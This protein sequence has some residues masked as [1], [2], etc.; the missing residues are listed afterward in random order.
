MNAEPLPTLDVSLLAGFRYAC[1]PE[2]GLCCFAEPRVSPTE[3][4]PLLSIAPG[5]RF[6][7]RGREECIASRSEGG[8]CALLGGLRCQGHA[9]RPAPCREFPVSVHLGERLQATVVLS[10]PG[11]DLHGLVR[12]PT[13]DPPP[14][15][16]GFDAELAQVRSRVRPDVAARLKASAARRR[17]IARFLAADDRWESEPEV[18]AR[19]TDRP[20][21]V[22]E[23][24]F[25][26]EPPPVAGDGLDLL[27]LTFAGAAGPWAIAAALGGWEVLELR[28][29]GGVARS[30][31]IV[32]PPER[33][34]PVA[35]DAARLLDRYLRYWLARDALFGVVHLSMLDDPRG[36]VSE[37]VAA[38]L[39]RIGAT[40]LARAD[41]LAAVRGGRPE[42][43]SADDVAL[44]IRATD[45][46]LLDRPTW[47]ARL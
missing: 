33:P 37:W 31:G 45:Q 17:R 25:P 34:P 42:R 8:A 19:W 47:G 22:P 39:A 10:C 24:A 18:R 32:P 9:A 28:E 15:P 4:A 7:T 13:A 14:A 27:P 26:V 44:G 43:L 6:V 40:V 29:T 5:L 16:I 11:V 21:E 46:D 38:E 12:D 35:P 1:R 3:R 2:C 20:V 30:L 36:T 23:S 41:V